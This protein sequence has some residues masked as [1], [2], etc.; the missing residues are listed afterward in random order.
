[1]A[2]AFEALH[3][4]APVGLLLKAILAFIVAD[5]LLLGFILLR[6]TYRAR[7]FARR[8]ARLIEIRQS[9]DALISGQIPYASWRNKSFDREIVETVVLDAFETGGPEE[10]ARLLKFLRASGLIEKHIFNA[11]QYRGWRRQRALVSLGRTRAPEG[12]PAL[13]EALRDRNPENRLAAL[14]GLG[15]MACP[16]A[17]E[18][19][20]SWLGEV[21]L[22]V[23]ALPLQNALIQCCAER[24]QVLLPF[25]QYSEGQL[26]EVLA[27]VLGEVATP[28]IAAEILHLSS[29]DLP[30]LRAATARALS[31]SQPAVA[32]RVLEDLA[33]DAVWFV[34]LRALVSL[35]KLNHPDAVSALLTGLSDANRLVR[36]RAG[37]ALI[38][39]G[40]EMVPI[41]ERVVSMHDRYGLHAYL[42]ALE[43]AGLQEKLEKDIA[44]S[45]L[46]SPQ[47]SLLLEALHTGAIRYE[48]AASRQLAAVAGGTPA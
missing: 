23:P 18:E 16:E 25:L 15:R 42:M 6:R 30:E 19:I 48:K 20:L 33:Q 38:D 14:R 13:S 8:D 9:W 2:S 22:T 1:M 43:N 24:P 35:G 17:A 26:R 31:N 40:K 7:Y 4:L 39:P 27:R 28:S 47:K 45:G 36:L 21:G 3:R 29:D 37:E 10:S 11:R 34:R 12:I 5:V 32:I 46:P 41:F 44:A